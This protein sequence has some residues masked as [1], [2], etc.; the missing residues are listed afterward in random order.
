MSNSA[1]C[2]QCGHPTPSVSLD[3]ILYHLSRDSSDSLLNTLASTFNLETRIRNTNLQTIFDSH[4]ENKDAIDLF[5][6]I[7]VNIFSLPKIPKTSKYHGIINA[8]KQKN[9]EM[10]DVTHPFIHWVLFYM[11]KSYNHHHEDSFAPPLIELV[12]NH[13]MPNPHNF[14]SQYIYDIL[15]RLFLL[16]IVNYLLA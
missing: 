3:F 14:R 10:L 5:C 12:Y 6:D 8:L 13:Y 7:L 1:L 11:L 9:H 2:E 4:T 16:D 15:W